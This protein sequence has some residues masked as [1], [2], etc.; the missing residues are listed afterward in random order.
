MAAG[1]PGHCGVAFA[2]ASTGAVLALAT[3]A[4]LALAAVATDAAAAASTSVATNT[5]PAA[6]A[7]H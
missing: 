6:F 3:S 4:T 1:A 5:A 2:L 7:M